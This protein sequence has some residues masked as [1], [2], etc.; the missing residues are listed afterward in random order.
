MTE[1]RIRHNIHVVEDNYGVLSCAD[2]QKLDSITEDD[3]DFV[4]MSGS[5]RKSDHHK[6]SV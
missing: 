2:H 5:K 4:V 3:E 6:L 1:P